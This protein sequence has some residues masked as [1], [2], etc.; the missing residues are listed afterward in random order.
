MDTPSEK[1]VRKE[2]DK[3]GYR[4]RKSRANELT[5]DNQGGYG[6]QRRS[7]GRMVA[8]PDYSLTLQTIMALLVV[9]RKSTDPIDEL[10]LSPVDALLDFDTSPVD[11]LIFDLGCI[12]KVLA[13][14]AGEPGIEDDE[15]RTA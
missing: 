1:R 3:R 15:P 13:P 14:P 6:V 2:L 12:D 7:D 4:L 11:A 8:G 5:V 10:K 9:L